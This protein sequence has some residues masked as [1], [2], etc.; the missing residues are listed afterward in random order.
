MAI[1]HTCYSVCSTKRHVNNK[2]TPIAIVLLINH[3][4]GDVLVTVAVV[5]CWSSLL[6]NQK[7]ARKFVRIPR[8]VTPSCLYEQPLINTAGSMNKD[9]CSLLRCAFLSFSST[10]WSRW[11]DSYLEAMITLDDI[12]L[13][14]RFLT[15]ISV[16]PEQKV[17]NNK[18]LSTEMVLQRLRARE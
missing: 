6:S 7:T 13:C 15:C 17:H 3:L 5:V 4:L 18:N 10:H 8:L 11:G 9:S 14:I 12:R 1:G 2:K 16:Q